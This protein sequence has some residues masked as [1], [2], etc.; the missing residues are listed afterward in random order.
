MDGEEDV[1]V[2]FAFVVS[3]LL[4]DMLLRMICEVFLSWRGK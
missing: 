3:V 4:V 1:K 2:V